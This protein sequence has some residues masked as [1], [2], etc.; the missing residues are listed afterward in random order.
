M[1]TRSV[2]A[3]LCISLLAGGGAAFCYVRAEALQ[4]EGR[5]LMARGSAQATEY[6]QLLDGTVADAQLKTFTERRVVLERAALWQRGTLLGILTAV[7]SALGAYVLFLLKRLDEQLQDAAA[8]LAPEP[9]DPRAPARAFT[10][11][12]QR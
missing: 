1:G 4:S 9:E 8:P 3:A 7:L 6:A 2:T 10:P 12:P 11:S 5:W